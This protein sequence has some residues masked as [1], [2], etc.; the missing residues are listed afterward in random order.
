LNKNKTKRLIDYQLPPFYVHSIALD[1]DIHETYVTVINCMKLQR[2][3]SAQSEP[4]LR[5]DG[6]DLEL[7]SIEKQ[8]QA[9]SP[10]DYQKTEDALIISHC[11][12]VFELKIVTRIYP[13][14]NTQLTGLYRSN[15]LY[16][17]QCEAE[18]FRRITYYP[19]RPDVLAV[20]TTRIVADAEKFP[21][22]LSNGN[23]IDSGVLEDGRHWTV[24]HDPFKKPSYLFALV[25]GNLARVSDI[26]ITQSGRPVGIYFYVEPGDEARCKHAI[27]SLKNAMRWDE[28]QFNREYDLDIY[29]VVAVSDFNMGAMENKGLNIFNK[30]YVLASEDTATDQDYTYIESVIAHEYFHNWTGN[31]VTCRDWFQLSL[32]EG[33]T[34]FRDQEFSRDM[35]SRDVCRIWD[36]KNLRSIQFPEDAGSM[37]HPV[38]PESY[39]EI[40]NFYTATIYEKGAEIIRMQHTLLGYEGFRKGMALYF[41][42]HDGQ[43][44]TIDDFIAAMSDAN[45]VDLTQFKQWYHKAGTPLVT[46][47]EKYDQGKLTITFTQKDAYIVPIKMALFKTTGEEIRTEKTLFVLKNNQDTLEID[48]LPEKPIVSLLREFSAPIILQRNLNTEDL[49]AILRVETDGLAKW[50]AARALVTKGLSYCYEHPREQWHVAQPLLDNFER[51][52]HADEMDMALR[53]ELLTPPSYEEVIAALPNGLDIGRV[54]AVRD[55]YHEQLGA[56]LLATAT[57]QYQHL[58][59]NEDHVMQG[60]AYA[61]RQYRNLC[62]WLLMQGDEEKMRS[63][64][65]GQMKRAVLMTDQ[66]AGFSLLMNTPDEELRQWAIG[67]FYRQWQ[68]DA[69]VLDK[70]FEKQAMSTLPDALTRVESL[71]AH[72]AFNFANPNKVR[73]L[74]GA[75]CFGNP[76]HFH[77][78]DG[79][80]YAFLTDMLI[81]IDAINP[82]VAARLAKPFTQA[83][84]LDRSR[85]KAMHTELQRL[86]QHRL[87]RDLSEVIN[88]SNNNLSK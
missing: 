12:E 78:L 69:L 66:L 36:V 49:L 8:G 61:R 65:Q 6:V 59:S 50:D 75:F 64:C 18:G 22:L 40:N 43:A 79:S 33:L 58:W 1:F 9:L 27:T 62:L 80:G 38:Q 45:G 57:Q 13:Q 63:V 83:S 72:S 55:F 82:Q 19:D 31:R 73:S 16:C 29:M 2:N 60:R 87:S 52:M 44:V 14:K 53:A 88:K 54:E 47:I 3:H 4:D 48:N 32:K 17:S 56:A 85:Q 26:F 70:W 25:A 46:V 35:N 84:H 24:W 28:E 77:A 41:Q 21:T 86:A 51:I 81:K 39:E 11:D 34:V 71:L 20:F 37:A 10:K 23:R 74:V 15:G 7:I 76:R 5:L 68:H 42:R 67:S 30:K